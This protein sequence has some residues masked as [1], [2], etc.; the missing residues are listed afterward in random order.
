MARLLILRAEEEARRSAASLAALGHDAVVAPIV[1]C[2]PTGQ[3]IPA[4]DAVA[5]IATS[6]RAIRCLNAGDVAGLATVPFFAVGEATATAARTAGFREVIEGGGQAE[7]LVETIL[8]SVA[9]PGPLLYLAGEPRWPTVEATLHAAGFSLAVQVLYRMLPM[10][11][12]PE[13]TCRALAENAPDAVLHYSAETAALFVR[14]ARRSALATEAARP[15]HLCLSQA[16]ADAVAAL[17]RVRTLVAER[18]LE[19]ALFELIRGLQG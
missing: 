8:R 2:M 16:I 13:S 18:P 10:D 3:S 11:A 15:V 17:P 4:I 9:P 1:T 5:L 12:L 14:L 19:A 6:A 7:A